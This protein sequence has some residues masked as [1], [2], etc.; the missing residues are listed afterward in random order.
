MHDPTFGLVQSSFATRIML[1][2]VNPDFGDSTVC[3]SVKIRLVYSATYGPTGEQIHVQVAPLTDALIDTNRYYSHELPATGAIIADTVITLDPNKAIFNGVDSLLGYMSFDADPAYF[4]DVIFDKAIA[5]ADYFVDNSSFVKAVPGLHFKDVGSG[6]AATAYFDLS[7]SG[8]LIQL[9]YHVGSKDTIPKVYNLTFGQN[10]GDPTF[11]YNQF[12][13]DFS[14][15]AFDLDMMDTVNGELLT[16]CQGGAGARTVWKIKDLDTLIGK[17]YSINRADMTV[18]VVQGTASPYVLPGSLLLLE[19]HDSAQA[20]VKDYSSAIF[21]TGGS[22]NRADM[23]EYR[24][25]FYVTRMVHEFVNE[26]ETVYPLILA[27]TGANSNVHRV[28]L[29]G[30]QHPIIPVEFNVYYTK[31]E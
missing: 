8:S 10:F 11:S 26:K 15:A 1:S 9:Y 13:H 23:R 2:K 17:G 29:A 31:S 7:A 6:N 3:D 25:R 30:G 18:H 24:Y 21:P 14:S 16:Y 27:T 4:Q 5:G 19:D 28:V 22:V 12:V 20:L